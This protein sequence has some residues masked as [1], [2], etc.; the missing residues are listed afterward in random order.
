MQTRVGNLFKVARD[1]R[2]YRAVEVKTGVNR[3]TWRLIEIGETKEPSPDV[4]QRASSLVGAPSYETFQKALGQDILEA[5]L[6]KY[7][8]PQEAVT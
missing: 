6:K 2:P 1:G 5:H 7:A 4:L 3:E 8:T